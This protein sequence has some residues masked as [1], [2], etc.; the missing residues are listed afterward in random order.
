MR[1]PGLNY[2]AILWGALRL[3]KARGWRPLRLLLIVA[4]PFLLL[5][6]AANANRIIVMGFAVQQGL[7]LEDEVVDLIRLSETAGEFAAFLALNVGLV[8]ILALLRDVGQGRALKR[9]LRS[10]TF[11]LVAPVQFL[12]FWIIGV[13][14][15]YF[16]LAGGVVFALSVLIL[17]RS[18]DPLR[19]G[20]RQ[21]M[22]VGVGGWL[23]LILVLGLFPV[24]F[25][26]FNG[27]ANHALLLLTDFAAQKTVMDWFEPG[28]QWLPFLIVVIS[29]F[30]SQLLNLPLMTMLL[31]AYLALRAGTRGDSSR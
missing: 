1:E 11:W 31:A 5:S 15:L 7:I 14:H 24:W 25:I 22:A 6:A 10:P 23:N 20:L 17:L 29:K 26:L 30:V 18:Q 2:F 8:L 19:P 16:K 13:P 4:A 12:C 28:S 3:F 21:A 9:L 27:Y